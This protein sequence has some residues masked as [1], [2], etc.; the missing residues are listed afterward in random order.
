MKI[1]D[2]LKNDKYMDIAQKLS[3][4]AQAQRRLFAEIIQPSALFKELDSF[5]TIESMIKELD[6]VNSFKNMLPQEI[7]KAPAIEL[8]RQAN[9]A[10]SGLSIF[11][12]LQ[13]IVKEATVVS[14][15]WKKQIS[16]IGQSIETS[17]LG[18]QSQIARISEISLLAERSLLK[19]DFNNIGALISA[20]RGVKSIIHK[21]HIS[22]SSSYASLYE[23]LAS[24]PQGVLA[25]APV[26]TLL[27][28]LEFYNYN[29]FL[30]AISIPREA[31]T[32]EDT[33]DVELAKETNDELETILNQLDP[34][35]IKLWRGAKEALNSTNPDAIRHFIISLRELLTHV[36][37][38]LSPDDEVKAWSSLPEH[39]YQNRPTRRAR[40]L[41]ICRGINFGPFKVLME[42]DIE[43]HIA[44]INL[45]Q[46][47]THAIASP[48]T[49]SQLETLLIKAESSIRFLI[50]TWLVSNSN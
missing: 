29:R 20:S 47:G 35:L 41:Y 7:L 13:S 2:I 17:L 50:R 36:I 37:H 39:Y 21:N 6:I 26:V 40:L 31:K 19:I 43:T 8:A 24:E 3:E 12:Q 5:R 25:Y 48:F 28:P 23:S 14:D 9:L 49:T 27:P 33:L 34:S 18:I 1:E 30:E 46:E 4:V 32:R 10:I 16:S 42:K 38:K 44:F 45:F 22:F 15:L 11:P